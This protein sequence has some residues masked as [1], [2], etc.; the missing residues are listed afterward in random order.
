MIYGYLRVST[1][2]QDTQK[3]K[4]GVLNFANEKKL[5]NVEFIEETITGKIHFSKRKLGELLQKIK[6]NDVLI[7][8]ELSRLAR[9]VSQILEV[10]N[11]AKEK[12]FTI[13]SLKEG[14]STSNENLTS[15]ITSTIFA[16]VAQIERDL[17]SL[18]TKEALISRKMKGLPLGR[19]KGKKGK[20]K[21]DPYKDRILELNRLNVPK[22][23]IAREFN[24]TVANLYNYLKTINYKALKAV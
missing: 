7:V 18:R 5:G 20:S 11:L 9:S 24:T 13:Y 16:L 21:L 23:K 14:F 2:L 1:Y 6:P 12:K 22:S 15:T 3:N 19:P 17:I 4:M 10:I 8:P